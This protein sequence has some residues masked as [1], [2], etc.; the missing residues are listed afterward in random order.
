MWG[1]S[2]TSKI[3]QSRSYLWGVSLVTPYSAW[4]LIKYYKWQY[5]VVGHCMGVK[6]SLGDWSFLKEMVHYFKNNVT[7]L[8]LHGQ[9][10]ATIENWWPPFGR[11][12]YVFA[13]I[14]SRYGHHCINMTGGRQLVNGVTSTWL[15]WFAMYDWLRA[16]VHLHCD[17]MIVTRWSKHCDLADRW[18]ST[19]HAYGRNFDIK[20]QCKHDE[21]YCKCE[22]RG[23]R[24]LAR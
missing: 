2:L 21:K 13:D 19:C 16:L 22:E 17:V 18:R 1:V 10:V 3:G 8:D 14:T 5:L 4:I 7:R 6:C 15:S 20:M 24:I 11:N 12:F 23:L 9:V